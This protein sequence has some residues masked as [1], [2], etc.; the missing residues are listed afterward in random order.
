MARL[1]VTNSDALALGIA[2]DALG[3]PLAQRALL[4]AI[5]AKGTTD[6]SALDVQDDPPS[7][8]EQLAAA[9]VAV[10][11]TYGSRH[12][13]EGEEP[14]HAAGP[15]TSGSITRRTHLSPF[16]SEGSNGPDEDPPPAAA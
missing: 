1:S 14:G 4:A 13:E 16:D 11:H 2:L 10:G 5:V 6:P 3:L 12:P 15:H 7:F 8:E 9:F